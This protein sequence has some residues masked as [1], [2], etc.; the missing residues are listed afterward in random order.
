M[1]IMDSEV[2]VVESSFIVPSKA[3]PR[4]TE[5]W[6]SPLDMEAASKGHTPILFFYRTDDTNAADFFDVARLKEAMAKALVPFYPLAGRL[7]VDGHGRVKVSCNDEGVLFIVARSSLS[8]GDYF[9]DFKPSPELRRLFLPHVEPPS[10][11]MAI[12]VTFLKHGEVAVGAVTHHVIADAAS[13]SLFF[14]AWSA[15][16]RDG[17]AAAVEPPCHD[18]TLLRARS[19]PAVH[20]DALLALCP[21]LTFFPEEPPPG[22]VASEVFVLSGDQVAALK[23]VC[24]GGGGKPASTFCAVSALVWQCACAARRLP[25]GAEA[26]LVFP[27][28]VRRRL[29]PPLPDGYFGNAVVQLRAAAAAGE[30]AAEALA[31]TAGRVRAAVG[32]LDDELVRSAVDY[33]HLEMMTMMDG[34]AAEAGSGRWPAAGSLPETE[35]RVNSWLGARLEGV[36]F[37]WGAPRV[38][39]RAES[40]RGGF[41]YLMDGGGQAGGEGAGAVRVLVCMEAANIKE[42]ER[43]LDARARTY[44]G[45]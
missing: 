19:P 21:K 42:F 41:V 5:L 37:G 28:S 39:S 11:I 36:D 23:R 7:G 2:Q 20:P 31:A 33:H 4:T 12:Q 8:A 10:V 16:S 25:P 27:A 35:L 1:P 38:M 15:F 43:L 6:L 17:D 44:G 18:R 22:A 9:D 13:A 30:V 40:V 24:G 26:R 45:A 14:Q 3:T 34:A 29:R 32:R